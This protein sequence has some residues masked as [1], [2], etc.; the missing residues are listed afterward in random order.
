MNNAIHGKVISQD[1]EGRIVGEEVHCLECQCAPCVVEESRWAV[2]FA[3]SYPANCESEDCQGCQNCPDAP[4]GKPASVVVAEWDDGENE[5]NPLV[6]GL[7][8]SG[9][10]ELGA[11]GYADTIASR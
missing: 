7:R 1:G 2:D 8:K 5:I 9:L 10:M 4:F 3:V 11:V 6:P